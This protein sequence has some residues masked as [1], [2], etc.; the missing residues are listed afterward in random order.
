MT[1]KLFTTAAFFALAVS[2]FAVP[3]SAQDKSGR[4][5]TPQPQAAAPA[6]AAAPQPVYKAANTSTSTSYDSGSSALTGAYVGVYG[7]YGWTDADTGAGGNFDMD[8]EDYGLFAGYKL[9]RL[10]ENNLGIT[11]AVEAFYGW[12]GQ[13]DDVAGVK[14]EKDH[15]WGVSFRPGFSISETINPYAILGYRRTNFEAAG[16]DEDYDGFDLGIGTE[17]IAWGNMGL[18]L[19][20]THTFYGEE[21]GVDPDEDNI[22]VGLSYHF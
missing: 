13:E 5:Y 2:A 12:S 3:A 7:G 8:G 19:D 11:A 15:E 20:Y 1:N 18:R 14:L 22:R 9:D 6:P 4:T 21:N 16:S 17:L 10:F